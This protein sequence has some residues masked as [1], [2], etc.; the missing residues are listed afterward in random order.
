[1]ELMV[2]KL[3]SEGISPDVDNEV[4]DILSIS[5]KKKTC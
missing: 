3:L 2:V 1:M 4:A 5:K